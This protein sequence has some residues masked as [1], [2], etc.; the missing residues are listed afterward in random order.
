MIEEFEYNKKSV[1]LWFIAGIMC[2]VLSVIIVLFYTS[3]LYH[4]IVTIPASFLSLQKCKTIDGC[5]V[6]KVGVDFI[7]YFDSN[8]DVLKI[9]VDDIDC[10]EIPNMDDIIVEEPIRIK[11]KNKSSIEVPI[12]QFNSGDYSRLK[13]ALTACC[14]SSNVKVE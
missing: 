7:V 6:M 11:I 9:S 5:V 10:I 1:Y 4:L 8:G 14:G 13:R 3:Q 12:H 2:L